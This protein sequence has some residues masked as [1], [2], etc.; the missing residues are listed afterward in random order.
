MLD[1][2]DAISGN[3]SW[4]CSSVKSQREPLKWT[5]TAVVSRSSCHTVEEHFP[6]E[7]QEQPHR[8]S[9]RYLTSWPLI[10][11]LVTTVTKTVGQKSRP[12]TFCIFAYWKRIRHSTRLSWCN[13]GQSLGLVFGLN[14]KMYSII[15]FII[16]K[17][18]SYVFISSFIIISEV[19]FPPIPHLDLTAN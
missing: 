18:I 14:V 13:E 10:H 7:V 3:V 16:L 5:W 19:E 17:F 2:Y 4:R 15:Y 12:S 8:L 1:K 6:V 11:C 9:Y